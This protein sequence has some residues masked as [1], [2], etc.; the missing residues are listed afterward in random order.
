V[1]SRIAVLPQ[2]INWKNY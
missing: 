2:Q 1:I